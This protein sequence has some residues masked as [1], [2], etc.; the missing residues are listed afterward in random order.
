MGRAGRLQATGA[1]PEN[2]DFHAYLLD[3]HAFQTLDAGNFVPSGQLVE[4]AG[5]K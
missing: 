1:I 5:L 4:K 3:I 2:I